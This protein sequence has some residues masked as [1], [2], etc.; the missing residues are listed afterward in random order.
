MPTPF[1]RAMA[2][3]AANP[4]DAI[5]AGYSPSNFSALAMGAAQRDVNFFDRSSIHNTPKIYRQIIFLLLP[6]KAQSVFIP[7]LRYQHRL[8]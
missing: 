8:A 5:P 7:Q 1:V 6:G 2:K 3:E 4:R